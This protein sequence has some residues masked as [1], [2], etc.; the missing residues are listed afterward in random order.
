MHSDSTPVRN[1]QLLHRSLYFVSFL[2]VAMLVLVF[3]AH[4]FMGV[5]GA[6]ELRDIVGGLGFGATL[7]VIFVFFAGIHDGIVAVLLVV[8][9]KLVPSLP[10][11]AVLL[12]RCLDHRTTGDD[13]VWWWTI[14]MGRS[15]DIRRHGRCCVCL[16]CRPPRTAIEHCRLRRR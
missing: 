11:G 14:R 8:K 9:G 15:S 1:N 4:A 10:W 12:C 7:T 2:P 6:Q 16:P 3:A 5:T 13:L